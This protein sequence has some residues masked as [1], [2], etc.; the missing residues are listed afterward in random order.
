[1]REKPPLHYL[2]M[3]DWNHPSLRDSYL[4]TCVIFASIYRESVEGASYLGGVP[5]DE[6]LHFQET[7]STIVLDNLERWELD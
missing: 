5:Q 1:M 6:A 7:A 2:F 3:S 4:M